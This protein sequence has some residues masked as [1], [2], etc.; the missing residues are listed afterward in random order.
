MLAEW[1]THFGGLITEW[2]P[3]EQSLSDEWS[4]LILAG[5]MMSGLE[6]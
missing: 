2:I 1:L 6:A 5:Q 4:S 3:V